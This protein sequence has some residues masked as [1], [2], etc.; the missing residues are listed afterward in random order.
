[1]TIIVQQPKDSNGNPQPMVYDSDTKKIIVDSNGYVLNGSSQ[2]LDNVPSLLSIVNTPKTQTSGLYEGLNYIDSIG[3]GK[4]IIK[5]IVYLSASISITTDN[6]IIIEGAYQSMTNEF[7]NLTPKQEIGPTIMVTDD[8]PTDSFMFTFSPV[9]QNSG[10]VEFRNLTII[11]NPTQSSTYSSIAS[12]IELTSSSTSGG[13]AIPQGCLDHVKFVNVQTALYIDETETSGTFFIDHVL[14]L[15]SNNFLVANGTIYIDVANYGSNSIQNSD[16][17]ITAAYIRMTNIIA[18]SSTNGVFSLSGGAI[19]NVSSAY[20]STPTP[21]GIINSSF[22]TL[23]GL[24]YEASGKLMTIQ[25]DS[26]GSTIISSGVFSALADVQIFNNSNSGTGKVLL[27]DCVF[28]NNGYT[29]SI[30]TLGDNTYIENCKGLDLV[31]TTPSV[32][33]SGTAQENTNP[34]PVNVYIYGGDITEI[35]ITRGGTAYTVLSVS[36]AIAMSGQVYKLNPGDSI[37]VTYT[38][39]PTWEW[40]SD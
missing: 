39:A 20:F 17:L 28:L 2:V 10:R 14:A 23:S 5:D 16:F 7:G 35:Q 40:L 31:P 30:G 22:L 33:T 21:I 18:L 34:Y 26:N 1:M 9:H 12:G 38:T 11:G 32:P 36:T 15:V 19:V 3:G 37:T 4:I 24:I 29:I 13:E 8:F 6:P 25:G 27:S